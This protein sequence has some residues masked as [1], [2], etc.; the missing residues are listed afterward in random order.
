MRVTDRSVRVCGSSAALNP[1]RTVAD[2]AR[3]TSRPMP[4]AL[5]V[6]DG[7]WVI[8]EV[9]SALSVGSWQIEEINDPRT[10][11]DRLEESRVDAVIIDMQVGSKGGMAVIRSIRQAADESGRPRLVLL[12]DRSADEFLARRHDD[13]FAEASARIRRTA[14]SAMYVQPGLF[15]GR[16]GILL[17]LAGRSR[18]GGQRHPRGAHAGRLRLGHDR[19]LRQAVARP[20][21]RSDRG[22]RPHHR[23]ADR[24][25]GRALPRHATRRDPRARAQIHP[26]PLLPG[27]RARPRLG[28]HRRQGPARDHREDRSEGRLARPQAA[29]GLDHRRG[30]LERRGLAGPSRHRRGAGMHRDRPPGPRFRWRH[31]VARDGDPQAHVAQATPA[32]AVGALW[33]DPRPRRLPDLARGRRERSKGH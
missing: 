33:P 16:A 23:R 20:C 14:R 27:G 2:A 32:G 28:R 12:L 5:V 8:N 15:T 4:T 30:P 3:L 13:R 10:V 17:Y 26:R 7:S 19:H 9:R 24:A 21:G 22:R 18:A 1:H 25:P 31:D 29:D 6:A 11:T